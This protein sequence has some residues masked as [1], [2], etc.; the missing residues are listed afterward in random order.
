MRPLRPA[1]LVGMAV[2][3]RRVLVGGFAVL[4]GRCRVLLGFG[5][6]AAPVVVGCLQVVMGGGDVA[7]GR[8]VMVVGAFLVVVAG[9]VLR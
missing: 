5:V 1:S 6:V 2:R 8:L 9:C 4:A 7:G 3:G